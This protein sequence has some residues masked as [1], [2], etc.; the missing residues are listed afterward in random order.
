MWTTTLFTAVIYNCKSL[1]ACSSLELS[2]TSVAGQIVFMI[3]T[4][5]FSYQHDSYLYKFYQK[6]KRN[7]C[8]QRSFNNIQYFV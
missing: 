4:A 2:C 8:L 3:P 5:V 6:C 1:K 7:S